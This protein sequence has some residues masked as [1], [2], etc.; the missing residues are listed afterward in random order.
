MRV[1]V[2]ILGRLLVQVVTS[3][4]NRFYQ[5]VQKGLRFQ[6]FRFAMASAVEIDG[7]EGAACVPHYLMERIRRRK[8]LWWSS[9]ESVPFNTAES[10]EVAPAVAV[11]VAA[12]IMGRPDFSCHSFMWHSRASMARCLLCFDKPSRALV[13]GSTIAAISAPFA[14]Y[15]EILPDV[16]DTRPRGV[17]EENVF[18]CIVQRML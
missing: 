15:V 5:T 11:S 4:Q 1:L 17:R 8:F 3:I 6:N 9:V 2:R 18:K 10:L 14:T 16:A 12:T 13:R 7:R